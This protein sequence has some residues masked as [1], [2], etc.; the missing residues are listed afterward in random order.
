MKNN[1]YCIISIEKKLEFLS[2]MILIPLFFVNRK[3]EEGLHLQPE[4][5]SIASYQLA[6]V[7]VQI[8]VYG[9][10]LIPRYP[11]TR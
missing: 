7:M 11:R 3:Q 6:T 10:I 9:S 4:R 5:Q 2:S 8:I 1:D